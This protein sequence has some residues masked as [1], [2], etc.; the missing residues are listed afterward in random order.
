MQHEQVALLLESKYFMERVFAFLDQGNKGKLNAADLERVGI[1]FSSE[2]D[3]LITFRFAVYD[4]GHKGYITKP[5]MTAMIRATFETTLNI[6]ERDL[7]EL[8]KK[9]QTE[10]GALENFKKSR[11]QF[12][13]KAE[14]VDDK[15]AHA[16]GFAF[17][18]TVRKDS[19]RITAAEFATA[20]KK[21]DDLFDWRGLADD[22]A[23]YVDDMS[24]MV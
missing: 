9:D 6:R 3:D 1:M 15:I 24:R 21:N 23:D 5:D 19:D 2:T 11:A 16:V 8:A 20:N 17:E 12:T 4:V 22:L 14:L 13:A 7:A 18:T 10:E